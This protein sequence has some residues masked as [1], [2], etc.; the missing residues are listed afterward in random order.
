MLRNTVLV[1]ALLLLAVNTSGCVPL[2]AAGAGGAGTAMW[3]SGKLT[4]E[5]NASYD[6]TIRAAKSALDSMGLIIKKEVRKDDVAQIMS[7]YTDGKTIWIDLRPITKSKTKI[8]VRV[9]AIA[10]KAATRDVLD[11][12][13][14]YL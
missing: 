2:I 5:V 8:E 10:D 3:L 4:E 1:V 14:K 6:R 11:R 12:I 9:G 13:L 7:T